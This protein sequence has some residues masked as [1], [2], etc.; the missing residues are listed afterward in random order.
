[1]CTNVRSC[2][3]A[4]EEFAR[5]EAVVMRNTLGS[6]K[7]EKQM[8]TI[9]VLSKGRCSP[10]AIDGFRHLLMDVVRYDMSVGIWISFQVPSER[11]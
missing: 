9:G 5:G 1:M 3:G 11:A 4:E 7:L 10:R 6:A 2:K 8:N